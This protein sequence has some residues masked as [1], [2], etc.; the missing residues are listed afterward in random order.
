MTTIAEVRLWGTRIGAVSLE[1]NSNTAAFEYDPRFIPSGIQVAPIAM[2]LG[3][4]VYSFPAL[5]A[6]SFHGLP[7]LLADSLPDRFGNALV[8]TWLASQGRLPESFNAV[9]RLCYTGTRGM[10]AL[11]FAPVAGP[12]STRSETIQV[13]ELVKIASQILSSRSSLRVPF[14][15]DAQTDALRH[16]LHVGTSA[17]GARAKA[18]IAWNPDTGEVRSGQVATP[19]FEYW[20][21]KFDG[22]SGNRDRELNDPA[23]YGTVEYAYYLMTQKAGITMAECRLL[24]E[25]GRRHFMTRR[26]DRLPGG[27]KIHMQSLAAMAHFDFNNPGGHS[28]EQALL[29]MRQLGLPMED[30]EEQYRR[31]VFNVLARNQDDHVKNIAFLMDRTGRWR[32][33]PAYDVTYA[34]NPSG[35][36]TA[37]HQMSL[38]GKRDDFTPPD[39]EAV[40]ETASLSKSRAAHIVQTVQEALTTWPDCARE[41]GVRAD[42]IK[43]IAKNHRP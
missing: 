6:A 5:P 43:A 42:W 35:A 32:L 26:F 14:T 24:E 3:P 13:S 21:L 12:N 25:S 40:A 37:R 17:G 36:W 22:V 20:L 9:E 30:L 11:E 23:G 18:V 8:D 31:M 33:S 19:G 1:E 38:N 7:G 34:Y 28:Y 27:D 39:F 10:G 2:P 16:I 29:I 41:A 4:R 15:P